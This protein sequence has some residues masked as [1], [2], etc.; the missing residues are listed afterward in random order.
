MCQ[1]GRQTSETSCKGIKLYCSSGR[2]WSALNE[3]M[4]GRRQKLSSGGLTLPWAPPLPPSLP[5]S[6]PFPPPSRP[7]PHLSLPTQSLPSSSPPLPPLPSFPSP[8]LP[9]P[10]LP[11]PALPSPPLPL[12]RG[13]GGI[14]PGK[15]L[16]FYIAAGEF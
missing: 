9:S 14:T 2:L 6:R 4:Q 12:K 7:F 13:S 1:K 11:S 15:F 5:P 10:S 3:Y 8:A 16:K